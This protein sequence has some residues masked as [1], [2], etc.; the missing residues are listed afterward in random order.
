MNR[1][2]PIRWCCWVRAKQNLMNLFWDSEAS[3]RR[4][5]WLSWLVLAVLAAVVLLTRTL[6]PIDETRYVGAAWEMWLR[7]DF[8]VPFKNGE[9]YS[10]KPPFF[11]WM[12]HV[13]WALFGI[14][15]W[16]PRLVA[17]L[18]SAG[19]SGLV[20]LLAL[21]LCRAGGGD[22]DG[23]A[24]QGAGDPAAPLAH[25]AV[26]AVVEPRSAP[27]ALVR[28]CGAGAAVGCGH[29]TG[30][31]HSGGPVG[32]GGLPQR[33]FLGP[34]RQPHGRVFRAQAA[35]LV[36]PAD[37]AAAA[38]PLVRLAR[39]VARAGR[40]EARRAGPRRTFLSGLAA[41][42]AHRLF[43]RQWQAAALPDSAVSG[44]RHAGRA[45]SGRATGAPGG[46]ACP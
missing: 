7:G 42:G 36:V 40:P 8:L 22:R 13:G 1:P 14:N 30:L 18:F 44:V 45:G 23:G 2:T 16:W 41:A 6:T 19:A 4:L 28:W 11:F 27:A 32:R 43:P 10:H 5:L 15:E 26:G 9:P 17:P 37:V 39:P 25:H 12:F 46:A 3:G 35:H 20:F 33:H 24:D 38:V 34:D 31:G 29:R 21:G